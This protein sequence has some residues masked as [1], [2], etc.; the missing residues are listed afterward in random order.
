[1]EINDIEIKV[2]DSVK[3]NGVSSSEKNKDNDVKFRNGKANGNVGSHD[4]PGFTPPPYDDVLSNSE[5][6]TKL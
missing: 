3:H 5:R 1:M 2:D 4:N 6:Y